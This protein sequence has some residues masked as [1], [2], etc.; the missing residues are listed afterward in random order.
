MKTQVILIGIGGAS[1][2]GKTTLATKLCSV[3]PGCSILHQDDF[4]AAPE[5]IPIHPE[6]NLPN[7]EDA[8]F[9]I[10]WPRFRAAVAQFKASTSSSGN[11]PDSDGTEPSSELDPNQPSSPFDPLSNKTITGWRDRF[12]QV[13]KEWLENNVKIVW[14]IVEGFLLFYDPE[15][16]EHLDVHI[17]LRS[18]R[19]VLQQRRKSRTYTYPNGNVWVDPPNYWEQIAYPEYV[20]A[21]SHL[22]HKG[23]LD[24]GDLSPEA[25]VSGLIVLDGQGTKRGLSSEDFFRTGAS[26]VLLKSQPLE[27]RTLDA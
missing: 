14:K 20:R 23:D 22:F 13:E 25:R 21:H 3:L 10:E 1:C 7:P 12:Q 15:V 27:R 11:T 24:A 16:V 8:E 18:P 6:Y 4:W 17:F 5:D 9:A 2:S 26:A 19:H